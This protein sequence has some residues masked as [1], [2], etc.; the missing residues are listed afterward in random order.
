[1]A[2]IKVVFGEDSPPE[3]RALVEVLAVDARSRV[4]TALGIE[5][6]ACVLVLDSA[7]SKS[8][9]PPGLG[10]VLTTTRANGERVC[11]RTTRWFRGDRR[12]GPLTAGAGRLGAAWELLS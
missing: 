9:C 12:R 2:H 8:A 6:A 3:Q 7:A 5:P 1:M 4:G 11:Q 10:I